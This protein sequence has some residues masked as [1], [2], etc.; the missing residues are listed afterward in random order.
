MKERGS[1]EKVYMYKDAEDLVR[2]LNKGSEKPEREKRIRHWRELEN[3]HNMK[4]LKKCFIFDAHRR[5]LTL[6]DD[7]VITHVCV[8]W[9]VSLFNFSKTCRGFLRSLFPFSKKK[10]IAIFI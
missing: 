10:K 4:F 8:M 5:L 7:T 1:E 2:R 9:K 3:L 6:S